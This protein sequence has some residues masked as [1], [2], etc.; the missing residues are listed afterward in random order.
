[1]S[2]SCSDALVFDSTP[3]HPSIVYVGQSTK[4]KIGE[5]Y[6]IT[7]VDR[8]ISWR[9]FIDR[10]SG[11]S[12]CSISVVD[13]SGQVLFVE[14]KNSSSGNIS[15]R[16]S[17]P[18]LQGQSY[19]VSVECFNNAGL[20]SSSCSVFEVDNTPPVPSGP[21]IAGVSCDSTSQYQ[22]D[23]ASIVAT[24]SP[25]IVLESALLNYQ[26]AIGTQPHQHD[27][28]SF[29]DVNLA[30]QV[31]KSGL[32]LSHGINTGKISAQVPTSLCIRS[33]VSRKQ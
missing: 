28:V 20:A 17:V 23:T 21:I 5:K 12:T 16:R 18:L 31:V 27:V 8:V 4:S 2:Q 22:S 11:I 33:F 3:P 1:M 19:N 25:F 14:S 6:F 29:E 26:F 32:S 30:T 15:L 9:E 24:W 13:Q 10:E 7:D